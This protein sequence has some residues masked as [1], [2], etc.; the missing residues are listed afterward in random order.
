MDDDVKASVAQSRLLL[1]MHK[2]L[3]LFSLFSSTFSHQWQ[4]QRQTLQCYDGDQQTGDSVRATDYII[5]LSYHNLNNRIQSCCVTGRHG[6][7]SVNVKIIVKG[8]WFLFDDRNYNTQNP[9]LSSWWIWGDN[10]CR[11]VPAGFLNK[12]SSLRF[13]GAPDDWRYDTINFYSQES[14][15]GDEFYTYGDKATLRNF[16]A[17]SVV[18]KNNCYLM[19][20]SKIL[21]I[22]L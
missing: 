8:I 6:N 19:A 10:I 16:Q 22:L 15:I 4:Q 13:T 9:A 14:F 17:G 7:C 21:K 20:G 3:Y 11:D 5:N 18:G 2:H 12:A 1:I